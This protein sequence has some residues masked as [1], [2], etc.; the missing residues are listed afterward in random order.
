MGFI[1]R[2]VVPRSVRRAAHPVRTARRAAT[3]RS[4]KS[5][6]RALHPVDN[7][8]YAAT[9]G[10]RRRRPARSTAYQSRPA[11]PAPRRL[12]PEEQRAA[13]LYRS[14]RAGRIAQQALIA[15]VASVAIH[16][17]IGLAV[18]PLRHDAWTGLLLWVAA[19]WLA[20]RRIDVPPK[21]EPGIPSLDL[22]QARSAGLA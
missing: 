10:S 1:T 16:A 22:R 11:R 13:T 17:L 2:A 9:R 3:P 21:V 14:R 12:T 6:R 4:V 15:T 19:Y 5:A 18:P 20:K 8:L 7:A